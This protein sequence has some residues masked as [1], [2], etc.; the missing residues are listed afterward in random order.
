MTT[1][2]SGYKIK[3]KDMGK[4]HIDMKTQSPASMNTTAFPLVSL[5][6]SLVPFRHILTFSRKQQSHLKE[7]EEN[8]PAFI[9]EKPHTPIVLS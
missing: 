8:A 1:Q 4:T 6:N 5:V 2:N 9:M 7:V 3:G